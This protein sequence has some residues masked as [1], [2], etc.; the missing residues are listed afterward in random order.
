MKHAT[1]DI[2]AT[3]IVKEIPALDKL[4][5]ARFWSHVRRKPESDCWIW[6]GSKDAKGYGRVIIRQK[7]YS[8]HRVSW[9]II[10]GKIPSSLDV[11]HDCDN[12]SCCN[13]G[14]LHLGDCATNIAEAKQRGR[15]A[16]QTGESNGTSKLTNKEAA[17]LREDHE[18]GWSVRKLGAKYGISSSCAFRI[19]R[20]QSYAEIN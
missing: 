11:L 19:I 4:E 13:P 15:L 2:N 17:R 8:A 7:L 14:H 9:S 20:R 10:N 6:I 5:T 1:S 12:P 16:R 3:P 18:R